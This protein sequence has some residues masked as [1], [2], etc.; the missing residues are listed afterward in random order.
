MAQDIEIRLSYSDGKIMENVGN[1]GEEW[2]YMEKVIMMVE[3][4]QLVLIEARVSKA[5][6]E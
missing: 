3:K 1:W 2:L 6:Q 5:S 4:M